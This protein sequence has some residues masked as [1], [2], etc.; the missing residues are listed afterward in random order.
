[1]TVKLLT[2]QHLEFLS[3]K[4]GCAGSFESTLVKITHSWKS[5]VVAHKKRLGSSCIKIEK[6][7]FGMLFN[8]FHSDGFLQIEKEM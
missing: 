8:H 4:G 2:N 6:A 7:A 5:R 3:L 1:M